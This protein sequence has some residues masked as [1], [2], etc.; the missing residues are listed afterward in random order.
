[1]TLSA[2]ATFLV[3][4]FLTRCAAF[5]SE[6]SDFRTDWRNYVTPLL[7]ETGVLT[8]TSVDLSGETLGNA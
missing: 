5:L 2:N 1:D 4:V 6:M 8:E 3:R 7:P